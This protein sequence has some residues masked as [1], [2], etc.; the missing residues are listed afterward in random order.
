MSQFLRDFKVTRDDYNF[1]VVLE[2]E[3]ENEK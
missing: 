1:V 3:N 2:N